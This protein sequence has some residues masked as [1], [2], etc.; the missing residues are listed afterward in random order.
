[1]ADQHVRRHSRNEK[2]PKDV[3]RNARATFS[4]RQPTVNALRSGLLIPRK[5]IHDAKF[6]RE[7]YPIAP[8]RFRP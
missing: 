5:P 6:S 4:P 1:M 2:L 7:C 3:P 8:R